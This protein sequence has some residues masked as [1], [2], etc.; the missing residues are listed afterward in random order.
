MPTTARSLG[1]EGQFLH[2]PGLHDM[3]FDDSLGQ[4]AAVKLVRTGGGL[5]FGKLEETYAVYKDVF[6]GRMTAAQ[7]DRRLAEVTLRRN[8]IRRGY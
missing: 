7:G 5:N 8:G 2:Q 4:T 1:I 6:H 3:A